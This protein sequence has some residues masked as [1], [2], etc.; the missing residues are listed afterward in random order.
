M[1]EED[2]E[3]FDSDEPV[4]EE[5]SHVAEEDLALVEDEAPQEVE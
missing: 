5:G 2:E 3:E 1:D 4:A